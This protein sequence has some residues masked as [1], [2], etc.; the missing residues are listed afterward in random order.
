MIGKYW[1]HF[2]QG[3]GV[4]VRGIGATMEE[5][6]EQ[7]AMALTAA[8]TDPK[9]VVPL[10]EVEIDCEAPDDE[11]LLAEWLNS[12]IRQMATKRMLFSHFDVEIN[13]NRLRAV[14]W[15]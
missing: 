12:L 5:A 15:G 6:F 1:E 8:I 4:G 11:R 9:G 14:V 10:E 3:A 7:I 13:A 2:A